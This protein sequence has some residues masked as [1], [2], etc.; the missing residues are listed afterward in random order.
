MSSVFWEK[1]LCQVVSSFMPELIHSF[2]SSHLFP[3]VMSG[4]RDRRRSQ[5][6]NSG[7]T[8]EPNPNL[9]PLTC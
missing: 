1:R 7:K 2:H 8:R 5:P 4:Y 3:R 6:G 9:S